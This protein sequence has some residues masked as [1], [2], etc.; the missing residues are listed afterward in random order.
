MLEKAKRKNNKTDWKIG[1]A[2]NAR[3]SGNFVNG[4]IGL[5]TIHHW[6]DLI[7]AFSELNRVLKPS[8]RIVIFTS[9]PEQ[10]KGYWLNHYFPKSLS[11]SII[12]IPTLEKVKKAM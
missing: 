12:P 9:T 5:L 10:M 3:L 6:T 11:N 7:R 4:I 1:T 8:G 2:E